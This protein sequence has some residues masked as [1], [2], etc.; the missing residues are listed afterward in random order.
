MP[1]YPPLS[2]YLPTVYYEL[3]PEYM[4]AKVEYQDGGADHLSLS[5]TP[6]RRW[7]VSY[8]GAPQSYADQFT[9]LRASTKYNSKEGSLLG[10]DFTPRGESLIANVRFDEGG[11]KITRTKSWVYRIEILLIK[12]P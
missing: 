12:R 9:P 6:I 1:T 10:M 7:Y 4:G 8:E 2:T 3:E 5:D 11:L